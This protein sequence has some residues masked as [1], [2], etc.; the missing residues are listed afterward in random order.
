MSPFSFY[1]F[2][3]TGNL[4]QIKVIP[5]LYDLFEKKLI[6][7]GSHI[8][9]V[10][11]K[12]MTPDQF[13]SFVWD[14]LQTPNRHHTH[15]IR[16]EVWQEMCEHL[17]YQSGDF[18]DPKL[19]S[20]IK[21]SL[22]THQIHNT[23]FYLATYPQLY[24]SIF[25][26]LKTAGLTNQDKGFTRLMLEKPIG[27]DLASAK[28]LNAQVS[29]Y[30]EES[31]VYRLDHYLGKETLQN[32]LTFRF[33]NGLLEHLFNHE[34]VDHIQITAS[35]DYGIGRRGTYFDSVGMLK[36]VGQNHSL[37]MLTTVTMDAPKE[38]S[39]EAVTRER[40]KVLEKLLSDPEHV[41]FGQYEGY[42]GEEFVTK[43]SSQDTFF[44]LRTTIDNERW[45]GVPIYIRAGK[46]LNQTCT[47]IS[48]VFKNPINRLFSHLDSGNEPNILTFRI[49][50]NEGIVF[51]FLSKVA[52]HDLKLEPQYMQFCY[53]YQGTD[54]PDAY[55][56][57]IS[58]VIKGDQTFFNDAVEVE[59][60]W[61]FTD[62]LSAI[63]NR[64][65]AYEQGSW[66]PQAAFELLQQD[67]REWLEPSLAMCAI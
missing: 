51:K 47:E 22:E 13:R 39:N 4:A 10:A 49:Q 27:I 34:F 46:R 29:Q 63:R 5:A 59:A 38:F 2:G 43:D 57:L 67:G 3:V 58:D 24:E 36:D 48:L 11:R 41:V 7:K 44:A 64:P 30:F 54:M 66:G 65:I 23:I 8:I 15:P 40:V 25:T 20:T 18:S 55:E 50:P 37:Q 9:G 14:I 28:R 21:A 60:Q 1:L 35:E 52:G 42:T 56:N 26:N 12:E 61:S 62:P 33:G 31:Q 32:I 17:S 53:K 16:D 45:Q 6:P 19:Y